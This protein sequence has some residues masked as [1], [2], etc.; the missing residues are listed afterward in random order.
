MEYIVS[1]LFIISN[2][3][4]NHIRNRNLLTGNVNTSDKPFL[5]LCLYLV[6][7]EKK[8]LKG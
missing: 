7:L 1:S 3:S 4:L 6:L 2:I 5:N 8:R